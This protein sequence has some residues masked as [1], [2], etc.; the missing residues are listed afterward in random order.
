VLQITSTQMEA[1]IGQVIW[2]FFRLLS[3]FLIAPVLSHQA[4]PMRVKISLALLIA[5]IVAP[6]L[7]TA[8][9]TPLFSP[10][11]WLLVAEQMLVGFAL[12]FSLSIVFAALELAGDMAGLQ[13]GIGFATFIDPQNSTQTPLIGSLLGMLGTLIFLGM[14]GH[15]QML[16]TLTGTFRIVPV[17]AGPNTIL[18]WAHFAS[19]GSQLFTLGLQMA[20]PLVTTMLLCNLA[21]GV[22]G[23]AASQLNL[24]SV[25]FT[26]TV[27]TGLALLY[28]FLPHMAAPLESALRQGLRFWQ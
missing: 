19:L 3:L 13:M 5:L 6:L 14:D 8:P 20:L 12:G 11:A 4:I 26:L 23:R 22:M 21:L 2:P 10:A 18:Q 16:D 15:L 25:G 17:G 28:L 1:W 7:P 27:L 24:F 9:A